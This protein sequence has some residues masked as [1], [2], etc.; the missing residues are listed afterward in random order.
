MGSSKAHE[1]CNQE[2]ASYQ[3][4]NETSP[5]QASPAFATRVSIEI[6]TTECFSQH[7]CLVPFTQALHKEDAQTQ[8]KRKGMDLSVVIAHLPRTKKLQ[9]Q[10][11]P[12]HVMRP[13]VLRPHQINH[14]KLSEQ[15]EAQHHNCEPKVDVVVTITLILECFC[16]E[17][18][19]KVSITLER[20]V[21]VINLNLFLL[22]VVG[23]TRDGSIILR[24]VTRGINL[25][26][27]V[28]GSLTLF[29]VNREVRRWAVIPAEKTRDGPPPGGSRAWGSTMYASIT[30]FEVTTQQGSIETISI[31]TIACR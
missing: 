26:L 8:A 29:L 31:E 19:S 10:V 3:S 4:P 14:E 23:Q 9:K 25:H 28:L 13:L 7:G 15:G 22:W 30:R 20:V 6:V 21:H 16:G 1:Y 18:A 5:S 12:S 17:I 11:R 27:L 2:F 24:S